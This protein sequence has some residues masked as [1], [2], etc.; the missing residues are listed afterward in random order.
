[1][2]FNITSGKST[3]DQVVSFLLNLETIGRKA[4]EKFIEEYSEDTTRFEKPIKRKKICTFA[5]G[6]T[7]FKLQGKDKEI[8]ATS[9]RDLFGSILFLSL[10][11][12]ID[13]GRF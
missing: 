3:N 5:I 6:N 13:M 9:M 11:Q 1:M 10:K 7:T 4:R 8:I 12:R 2:L